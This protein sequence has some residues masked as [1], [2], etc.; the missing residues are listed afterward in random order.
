[1]GQPGAFVDVQTHPVAEAVAKILSEII[2]GKMV[3]GDTV[4]LRYRDSGFDG[5]DGFALRFFD[6]NVNVLNKLAYSSQKEYA[7]QV[8]LIASHIDSD[9]DE[10]EVLGADFAASDFGVGKTGV[11]PRG[12]DRVKGKFYPLGGKRGTPIGSPPRLS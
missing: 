6:C 3:A 11:G 4:H 12:D 1:M 7:C 5:F 10:N 8:G 2:L 9:I